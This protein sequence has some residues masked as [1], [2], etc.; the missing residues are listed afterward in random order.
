MN[1]ITDSDKDFL[2]RL[3]GGNCERF[4]QVGDDVEDDIGSVM[5]DTEIDY[6]MERSGFFPRLR[7]LADMKGESTHHMNTVCTYIYWANQSNIELKF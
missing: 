7:E 6:D 2:L 1:T 5:M 3:D 4:D